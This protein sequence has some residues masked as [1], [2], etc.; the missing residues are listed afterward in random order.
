VLLQKNRKATRQAFVRSA[1]AWVAFLIPFGLMVLYYYRLGH[2]QEFWFYSFGVTS[3]IPVDRTFGE[4]LVYLGDFHLRFLPLM[5]FF[6]YA[7][8]KMK[9]Q[10]DRPFHSVRFYGIWCL[11]VLLAV[12]LP[13]K[14]FGHYFI[15]LMLP[16]S[17]VAGGFFSESLEKPRWL[18]SVT[19]F[20]IGPVILVLLVSALLILQK[21]DYFDRPDMPKEVAGYLRPLLK[22]GDRI[23]TGNYQQVLYYLLKKDCPVKYVHRTL[24]CDEEHRSALRIDLP[25]EMNRLMDMNFRFILMEKPYCYEPMNQ[26]IQQHYVVLKVIPGEVVIYERK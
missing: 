7:L 13:G 16:L 14:P 20:P 21:R 3:R 12:V 6:Y 26:Y 4:L 9:K 8:A 10:H 1:V 19:G 17:I 15:Q 18:R 24:M 23:F 11:M 5:F 2:L 22:S 25:E